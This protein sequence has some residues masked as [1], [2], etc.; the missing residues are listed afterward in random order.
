MKIVRFDRLLAT[1]ALGL[2]L[3]LSCQSGQAQQPA[4]DRKIDAAVPMPDTSFPPP[5]T[6]KDLPGSNAQINAAVPMPNTSFPPPPTAKDV[7]AGDRQINAAVPMPDTSQLPPLTA[8]DVGA[9]APAKAAGSD[10]AAPPQQ[11]ATA[12][13][14]PAPAKAASAPPPSPTAD[15]A[16]AETCR[17]DQRQG[18]D[19]DVGRKA[20]RAGVGRLYKA[21][22][23]APIW[24][25]RRRRQMRAPRRRS[26]ISRKA[27]ERRPRPAST[28]RRPDFA[29]R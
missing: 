14:V 16:V 6:A 8:K 15:T 9:V 23:Y 4:P 22:D 3:A 7:A 2:A 5:P 29:T 1:T 13:S 28:I 11:N 12:P 10:Q 26:P 25:S 20:D 19:R 18:L 24:V 27:D 21:H 17:A